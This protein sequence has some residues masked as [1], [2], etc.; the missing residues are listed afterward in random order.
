[1]VRH[2]CL[3]ALSAAA[4]VLAAAVGTASAETG[5]YVAVSLSYAHI[6]DA[7]IDGIDADFGRQPGGYISTDDGYGVNLAVGYDFASNW[8]AEVEL[9]YRRADFKRATAG[10]LTDAST[11]GSYRQTALFANLYYDFATL[12]SGAFTGITPYV[13]AGLGW[14]HIKW[15]D[16]HTYNAVERVGHDSSDN[17]TAA[18][19]ML[20]FSYALP[21]VEGMQITAELRHTRL[22]GDLTFKGRVLESRFGSFPISTDV[23]DKGRTEINI[24]LRRSF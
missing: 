15:S 17:T 13:G 12:Q 24:G 7:D 18:Q 4:V 9:N 23:S 3:A 22:L 2:S 6:E 1:M 11:D 5:P 21:E 8:R 16:A 20:G 19:I 14:A 10:A